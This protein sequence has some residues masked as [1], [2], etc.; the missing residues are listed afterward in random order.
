[1]SRKTR[2]LMWSVPLIA[3][4][5]V[6]GALAAFGALGLGNVFANELPDNPQNLKVTA[7]SGN[8]G[9][10]TL[11]LTWEAPASGAPDMY[12]IDV[13][14][15]NEKF[16][17]LTE[18]SGTTLTHS[19][20]VRP[21]GMDRAVTDGWERFYRIYGMNSHGY[22]AVSTAESAITNDLSV[23]GEVTGV[24]GSSS[25]PEIVNLSWTAPDDG[26]SD[27]WGYC[28][29]A[30]GPA[31][32]E[33]P[34][35]SV[36]TDTNCLDRFRSEGAGKGNASID[37][38]DGQVI[39]ILPAT[40][41]D[42]KGLRAEQEWTYKVYAFNRYGNSKTTT[43]E[44]T[45]ETDE[46]D[47]PTAPGDLFALQGPAA[48]V[49]LYWT[50][51][52]D[53]GQ[54]ITSYRVEVSNKNNYWP[55]A[56]FT[57]V[58]ALSGEG[59]KESSVALA[60][61]PGDPAEDDEDDALVAVFTLAANADDP[62]NTQTATDAHQFQYTPSNAVAGTLYYQVKTITGAGASE[63]MSAFEDTEIKIV[64]DRPTTG[65]AP[66]VIDDPSVEFTPPIP[67]P[68]VDADADG[69][70]DSDME[71]DDN[72]SLNDEDD[73]EPGVIKLTVT[74]PIDPDPTETGPL[75]GANSY[76]V[77]V[78]DD[79]GAT[80]TTVHTA[81]KPINEVEYEHKGLKPEEALHFRLF[82]KKGSDY[83]LASVP[84][85]DYAGNTDMPTK[86]RTLEATT[87]NAGSIKLS[88]VAP[89][90]DGGADVEQYCI[91]VNELDEKDAVDGTEV[92]REDIIAVNAEDATD[93]VT[94]C[95]RLGEPENMPISV[96][97]NK[98]FQVDADTT[99]ATF[100]SLEQETRWQFR[101][102]AL[103]DASDRDPQNDGSEGTR[104]TTGVAPEDRGRH[105][106]SAKSD[107]VNATTDAAV[108]PGAPQ[109]LT[110]QFALDNNVEGIGEQGV[111][112]LWNPP[113][114]PPGA[115]VQTYKIERS[116]DGEDYSVR[117]SSHNAGTTHWADDD[118]PDEGEVWTYRLT[119]I[120]DVAPG[121]E[122]AMVT[123]PLAEHTTHLPSSTALTA[124]SGVM[125]TVGVTDPGAITVTWTPG[126][127]A[128]G[129][130]LVLL[131]NSDF[132]AVPHIGVPT[133]TEED[134]GM[135]TI[136][137]VTTAGDYVV[138]VVS[139]KSRSEY[140]YDY[141]RVNVP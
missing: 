96:S 17:R 101:V 13:S 5:A 94:N 58:T 27:I 122:M 135:Y 112:L 93:D 106:L 47:D 71:N 80:W 127:N 9:R 109:R 66:N 3:A 42:H 78:S 36:V 41:Y 74:Q 79:G 97:G 69:M 118:E 49:N 56:S 89:E 124:P 34:T 104:E 39:R 46:A 81:T 103:N 28:I 32:V 140:L 14:K 50:A 16:T 72:E 2:K 137:D 132:T 44:L 52:D 45:I 88:W 19:Y 61:D 121:M 8:A 48:Q 120:N 95:S 102:Y 105:A 10:T 24:K 62:T 134:E 114:N 139:V 131:F 82:A 65:E 37:A 23:P 92:M 6:I 40:S 108:V 43:A 98:V 129:G 15:E 64:D 117:V 141:A 51:P 22:G 57:T 60:Q 110:A 67:A 25:D 21:K 75:D 55:S 76:R 90:D 31:H 18:V 70:N 84:V 123:I 119:A 91:I 86:V 29:L 26:G 68:G 73:T 54:N 20:L 11:V 113:A 138:V 115:P 126:E 85:M 111:L 77:D 130:H 87:L 133:E 12:R 1:M 59:A 4:V 33:D 53:G 99:M 116:V 125:A 38:A 100:S 83:G 63:K 30:L 136:P 7:A 128:T 107:K 35:G